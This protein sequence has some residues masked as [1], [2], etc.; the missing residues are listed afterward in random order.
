MVYDDG[1]YETTFGAFVVSD[2]TAAI[3]N[4][5]RELY[6]ALRIGMVVFPKLDAVDGGGIDLLEYLQ[7][8]SESS[9]LCLD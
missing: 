2:S 8:G 4:K 9:N 7:V 5:L 3:A 6:N 1:F